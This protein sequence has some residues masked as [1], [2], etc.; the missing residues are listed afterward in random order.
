MRKA[1]SVYSK[2][3]QSI[4]DEADPLLLEAIERETVL[5]TLPIE[6]RPSASLLRPHVL[7]AIIT[8]AIAVT[9]TYLI[10]TDADPLP[11]PIDPETYR[12]EERMRLRDSIANT[13]AVRDSL[14]AVKSL[15]VERPK[16][17]ER[18]NEKWAQIERERVNETDS[19]LGVELIERVNA[20]MP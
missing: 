11:E 10:L 16:Q 5:A 17:R 13:V 1:E 18:I 20:W 8:A 2:V 12:I 7:T 14:E 9:V 19:V 3:V 15:I 4:L 6:Q